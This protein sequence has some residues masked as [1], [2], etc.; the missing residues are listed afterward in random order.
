MMI[1]TI[2]LEDHT[3]RL[4]YA[5]RWYQRARGLSGTQRTDWPDL[6]GMYLRMPWPMRWPIWMHG[7]RIPIRVLWLRHGCIVGCIDRLT[8]ADGHR[9]HWPPCAVDAVVELF[10]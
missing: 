6:D 9:C 2:I 3:Y 4:A 8:P 7:M 10:D 1:R 5:A